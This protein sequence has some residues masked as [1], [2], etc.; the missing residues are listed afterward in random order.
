MGAKNVFVLKC[1]KKK[2][3]TNEEF[4]KLAK[5]KYGNFFDYS[6]VNYK[7]CY[8]KVDIICP[9]HGKFETTPIKHLQNE[10][11]C[12]LCYKDERGSKKR[13]NK[14]DFVEKANI[15]HNNRFDYS[16]VNY[17]NSRT[18]VVIICPEHGE[19]EVTPH[20][21]LHANSGCPICQ[22]QKII[23]KKHN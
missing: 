13:D 3:Y 17:I 22:K 11:G 7:G 6:F 10:Y 21:H 16:K 8:S 5:E 18:K 2:T 9:K 20:N 14:T 15:V 19:F 4:I 23:K 1:L 12:P